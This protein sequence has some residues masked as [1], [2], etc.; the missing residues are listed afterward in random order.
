RYDL[1]GPSGFA[2]VDNRSFFR[3]ISPE[4][5]RFQIR[6]G[7]NYPLKELEFWSATFV[8]HMEESGY[9]KKD[10]GKIFETATG[11]RGYAVEWGLSMGN[12]DY[13]YLTAIVPYKKTIFIIEAAGE[14]NIFRN[15]R[16]AVYSAM[17]SFSP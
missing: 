4:G 1:E 6:K 13:L 5:V 17:E 14:H 9:Q 8:R 2:L 16:E 7:K 3:A 10:D 12:R 11:V 15:Y